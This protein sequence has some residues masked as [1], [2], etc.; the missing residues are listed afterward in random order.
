M[1]QLLQRLAELDPMTINGHENPCCFFCRAGERLDDR[2]E[3][4]YEPWD[5]M[6]HPTYVDHA[7]DC[8]WILARRMLGLGQACSVRVDVGAGTNV[9]ITLADGYE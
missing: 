6:L 2:H 7:P 3:F 5:M 8:L 4:Y 1:Q 9:E